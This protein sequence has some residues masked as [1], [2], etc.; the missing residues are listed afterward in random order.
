MCPDGKCLLNAGSR[1]GLQN[2][3]KALC[4]GKQASHENNLRSEIC[5]VDIGFAQRH[6]SL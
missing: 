2:C 5:V 4:L 6:H 1:L 3:G